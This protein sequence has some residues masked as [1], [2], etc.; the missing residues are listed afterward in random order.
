MTRTGQGL[1]SLVC[2]AQDLIADLKSELGG[3]FEDVVMALM[4]P[5]VTF[6][7]YQLRKAMKV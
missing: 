1:T 3:D 4:T 2:N 7:A 5:T 6:L